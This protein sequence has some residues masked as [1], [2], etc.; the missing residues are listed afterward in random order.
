LR[1]C[2]AAVWGY[3]PITSLLK[4]TQVPALRARQASRQIDDLEPR[5][6][7]HGY[8]AKSLADQFS[9]KPTEITQF[10]AGQLDAQRTKELTEQML[11]AGLPL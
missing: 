4:V 7:R 8:D 2:P 11:A 1:L 9:T 6:T 10:I 5:L 3:R